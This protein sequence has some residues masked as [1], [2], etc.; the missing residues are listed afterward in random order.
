V[1]LVLGVLAHLAKK[2]QRRFH[3]MPGSRLCLVRGHF[4]R[5]FE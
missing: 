1:N 5:R 2:P 4:R 3:V